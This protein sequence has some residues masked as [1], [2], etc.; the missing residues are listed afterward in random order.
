MTALRILSV[1]FLVGINAFF[2]AVEF[3]L[4]AVRP[5]RIRQLVEEGD[6]RAR[7]VQGLLGDLDRVVSGVQVGIT[8][9]SLGLGA[10]GEITLAALLAPLFTWLPGAH[11]VV[12]THGLALALAFLLLTVM[13]VVLGELVPKSISLQRA[14]R[15]ALLV[16]RPFSW[17][18]HTFRWA[19]D[20][21]DRTAR[22]VTRA[23]GVAAPHI[24]T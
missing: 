10:L 15:V 7:V 9:T 20:L 19:I 14:E 11:A 17:F 4:V 2:A 3:S 18:L 21:L 5:S 13:H 1:L 23:L 6:A 22:Q 12:I 8:L 24:H 16:A